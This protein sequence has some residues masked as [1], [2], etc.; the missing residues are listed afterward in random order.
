MVD[1]FTNDAEFE[2]WLSEAVTKNQSEVLKFIAREAHS[3]GHRC[4]DHIKR[5][6]RLEYAMIGVVLVLVGSG[7]ITW[8][9]VVKVIAK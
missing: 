7:L 1:C 5:I 8:F 2:S 6:R 9:D 4:A 3:T